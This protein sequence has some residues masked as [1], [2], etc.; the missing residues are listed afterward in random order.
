MS[1]FFKSVL[2]LILC[3]LSSCAGPRHADYRR[4]A[5]LEDRVKREFA[6]RK[7]IFWDDEVRLQWDD[8]TPKSNRR[9]NYHAQSATGIFSFWNCDENKFEFIVGTV[10][11]LNKSWVQPWVKLDRQR[12]SILLNHEQTHFDL[13]EVYA[14]KVRKSL[15][16]VSD[17]CSKSNK[18]LNQI[19]NRILEEFQ[20][21][22]KKYD[23]ETNHGLD[24]DR[25]YEWDEKVYE[26]LQELHD[27]R[28]EKYV[29]AIRK[30][31]Q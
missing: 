23:R 15:S 11:D 18:E 21:E 12:E 3:L 4:I 31:S 19:V 22:E 1:C 24:E 9:V 30:G 17:P 2:P 16:E 25:Q 29:F 5:T 13:S 8:F 14:R 20:L 27:Y 10:F 7:V 26:L 6:R 28:H